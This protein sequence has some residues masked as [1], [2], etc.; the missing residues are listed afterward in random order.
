MKPLLYVLILVFGSASYIIGLKE[1]ISGKYAP[2]VFSR[3]VWIMLAIISF[4]GVVVSRST[5]ASILLAGI[6]LSG[7]AA[8][9]ITS[10]WKGTREFNRLEFAC[11]GILLI[12]ALVWVVFKA[13]LVSLV[14]SLLAHFIGALPTYKRVLLKPSSESTRFWS[15]FFIA[16]ILSIVASLGQPLRLIIFPIYFTIFDG[17]MTFLSM[18]KN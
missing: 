8:I 13:P 11:L 3:V 4:A 5:T 15:L 16:S 14:I 18:R 9:C 12:S 7:N 6:L 1:M 2:S 17:S 10:F